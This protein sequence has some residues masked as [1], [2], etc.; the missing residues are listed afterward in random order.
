MSV[1]ISPVVFENRAGCRLMG[2][3]HRPAEVTRDVAVLLLSPGIK[4][5]VAPHRMYNKLADALAEIGLPVLRFDFYGLGDSEGELSEELLADVYGSIQSGR[6]SDDTRAGIDWIT[7]ELGV[8]RVIVGG[9]CGGA[10]TGLLAAEGDDRVAGLLALGLPVILDGSAVDATV[11]MTTGQ[12]SSLREKY[13]AKLTSPSAWL[14]LLT[15][16]TDFR[17]LARSIRASSKRK[18]SAPAQP[19]TA[20]APASG[21]DGASNLNPRFPGAFARLLE[22]SRP[23]LLVF[24]GADRLY[25]EFREKYADPNH[26]LL[27][28]HAALIDL[29]VVEQANHVF[30]FPEWQREMLDLTRAWIDTRFP[31]VTAAAAR[32]SS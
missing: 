3:L 4:S 11:H 17:L 21:A 24:S 16:Q 18:P 31:A 10:I 13:L 9:L 5:R 29:H 7:R 22:R 19:T 30:T 15:L 8:R 12:L 2:I 14:R 25:W 20:Q 6:Y 1:T 32:Q 28:R 27:E 26:A 23:M